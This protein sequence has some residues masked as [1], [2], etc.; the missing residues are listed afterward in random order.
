MVGKLCIEVDGLETVCEGEEGVEWIA[1]M[2]SF[3]IRLIGYGMGSNEEKWWKE[4]E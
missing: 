4:S 3:V 2:S 1:S